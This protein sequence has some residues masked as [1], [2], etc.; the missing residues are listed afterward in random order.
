VPGTRRGK[1]RD[2]K[3]MPESFFLPEAPVLANL[4]PYCYHLGLLFRENSRTTQCASGYP[5]SLSLSAGWPACSP[6]RK[7]SSPIPT[8]RRATYYLASRTPSYWGLVRNQS[9]AS[10]CQSLT[11]CI[12][13]LRIRE[14]SFPWS[15]TQPNDPPGTLKSS[16]WL[17]H[18]KLICPCAGLLRIRHHGESETPEAPPHLNAYEQ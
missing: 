11:Q 17:L 13:H 8:P 7:R 3:E 4:C 2:L 14:D 9:A 12:D 10:A 15:M 18:L 6:T 16:N 1:N 5:V